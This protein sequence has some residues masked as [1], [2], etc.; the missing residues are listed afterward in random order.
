[1]TNMIVRNRVQGNPWKEMD[2]IWDSLYKPV[3]PTPRQ[4]VVDIK[5]E[6]SRVILKAELPGFGPEDIDI[7]VKEN[8]LTVQAFKKIEIKDE[9]KDEIREEK[10]VTF[11]KSF[12]LPEDLNRDNFEAEMK[13]GLLTLILPRNEKPAP[14]TI[15]VKG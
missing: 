11:E 2:K 4:P 6:E 10:E 13:N 9:T 5:N 14:R 12:I 1:M 3:Q 7:Q 8:L 15:K